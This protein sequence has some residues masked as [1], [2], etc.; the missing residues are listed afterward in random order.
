MQHTFITKS[1]QIKKFPILDNKV[2]DKVL[3]AAKPKSRSRANMMLGAGLQYLRYTKGVLEQQEL[4]DALGWRKHQVRDR[5]CGYAS[6]S[7]VNIEAIALAFDMPAI[8]VYKEL[9]KRT[10]VIAPGKDFKDEYQELKYSVSDCR[11]DIRYEIEDGKF[12]PQELIHYHLSDNQMKEI[13]VRQGKSL[14]KARLTQGF[15]SQWL[16]AVG[17]ST[18]PSYCQ[19]RESGKTPIKT[20][21]VLEFSGRWGIPHLQLAE[22]LL[23]PVKPTQQE[24]QAIR[25][26]YC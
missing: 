4:S 5:E 17:W 20:E 16:C 7:L 9:T 14:M 3:G 23:S 12:T 21:E 11:D 26:Q 25:S 2:Y 24:L 18:N 8:E 13:T 10:D 6:I 1:E 22:I 15:S 19:N